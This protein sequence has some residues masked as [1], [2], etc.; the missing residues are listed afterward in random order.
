MM[1]PAP[2]LR[3]RRL[4]VTADDFGL[5]DAVNA[6]VET[7]HRDGIL[8]AASL[9]VTGAAAS[10]AI[11]RA[12]QM[13]QL[14]IGLHLALVDARP[15]LMPE[16]VPS[17]VDASGLFRANMPWA[18]IRMFF[19][20]G[21]RRQLRAE[22]WA[23]FEAYAATGLRCD[24]VN[25]HK[26]FHMHPTIAGLLFEAA[27]AFGSPPIRVPYEHTAFINMIEPGSAGTGQRL[28]ALGTRF[29]RQRALAQGFR[30]PDRVVGLAWSGGMDRTRLLLALQHV[31]PGITEVYTHPATNGDFS[32]ATR[33]YHYRDEFEALIAPEILE[34]LRKS[35]ILTGG[36]S[37]FCGS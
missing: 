2:S 6:A 8:T 5:S 33:N 1:Q 27:R 23:Q 35:D 30:M 32:G 22:I 34:F 17:L 9:M 13:P 28:F 4:I 25:A 12:R 10:D 7:A 37:D 15:V 11:H 16:Q 18:G 36:Y 14:K 26:H 24:H 20:P 29:L 3:S 31:P 19:D 21:A